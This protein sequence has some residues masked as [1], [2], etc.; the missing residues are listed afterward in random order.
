M[1]QKPSFPTQNAR[2]GT[3]Q[4]Q[5]TGQPQQR[6]QSKR[7][8]KISEYGQQLIEK[9]KTKREYGMR[10][11][12]FRRYF[13]E[14]SKF[15]GQTGTVLLQTLE[16]RIDNV[17]FRAGLAKTRPQ[18]R[19][20]ASHRHFMLNDKRISVASILVKENDVIKPY[21]PSD[22]NFNPDVV[23]VDWLKTEKKSGKITIKRIPTGSDLPIEFDTQ[24]IIEFYSK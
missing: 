4:G 15:S 2:T 24:K 14:S 8:K 13:N 12:Q 9:Q 1:P 16:R 7:P 17:I 20:L 11:A 22:I 6:T 3:A 10:E 21:K 5:G 18:A 19:Q 23:E